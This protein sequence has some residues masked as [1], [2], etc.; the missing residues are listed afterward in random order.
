MSH[1]KCKIHAVLPVRLDAI[2][3][4]CFPTVAALHLQCAEYSLSRPPVISYGKQIVEVREALPTEGSS[5]GS[6][7][8]GRLTRVSKFA[9]Q[10]YLILSGLVRLYDNNI[11]CSRGK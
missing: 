1:A 5:S 9:R 11:E 4:V 2:L 3:S 10:P 7:R 6:Y 8:A